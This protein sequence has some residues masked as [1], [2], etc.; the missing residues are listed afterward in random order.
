MAVDG[1]HYRYEVLGE[2]Y[3]SRRRPEARIAALIHSALGDAKTVL[4]V[5][6]GAG[7]YEPADRAVIAL[8]PSRGMIAQRLPSAA[9][10]VQGIAEHLP[11]AAASFD[12]VMAVLTVHHWSEPARAFRELRRVAPRCVILSYEPDRSRRFWLVADYLPAIGELEE[13]RP[14]VDQVA[15]GIGA[16]RIIP[17]P[18]PFDC[19]DGFLGAYWRRPEAYLDPTVRR[20]ISS[21]G[22][23]PPEAVQE[24]ISRL[25]ADLD[26]GEWH[27]RYAHLLDR[28]SIDLG[29]RLIVAE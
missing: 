11:F 20:A 10:A 2:G 13:G 25:A 28:D 26:S 23:V 19:A 5:G 22:L 7:S 9:P 18:I 15:E 21:F 17:I 24:G 12:A 14:T 16:T 6:A 1:S 8:E 29:Y 27:R 4:N 3:A